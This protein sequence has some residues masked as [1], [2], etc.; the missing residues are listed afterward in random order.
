MKQ[1]E[2]KKTTAK[3]STGS[4]GTRAAKTSEKASVRT[5]AEVPANSKQLIHQVLPY[6]FAVVAFFLALCFFLVDI[7]NKPDSMG[8]IGKFVSDILLGFFGFGA[9]LIPLLLAYLAFVWRKSI[10]AGQTGYKIFFSC[11]CIILVSALIHVCV[12]QGNAELQTWNPVSLWKT[13]CDL[14]SGGIVGG[15]LGQ[16]SFLGLRFA[17]SLI[18]IIAVLL[19]TVMFLF[20]M[21][22]DN[23]I[24]YFKYKAR[25]RAERKAE[26]LARGEDPVFIDKPKFTPREV[27]PE[28]AAPASRKRKR[29]FDVDIEPD[30]VTDATPEDLG[31]EFMENPA[32]IAVAPDEKSFDDIINGT[33]L[34]PSKAVAAA[35]APLKKT[36]KVDEKELDDSLDALFGGEIDKNVSKKTEDDIAPWEDKPKKAESDDDFITVK[37][38]SVTD[39]KPEKPVFGEQLRAEIYPPISLLAEDKNAK[40][41]N[42]TAELRSTAEKLQETLLSFNVKTKIVGYSRGP[43]V[44]RYELQ[45]EAGTRVRSISNLVDDIALNLAASGGVRI[46]APIP[47]KSAVGIEV[48]NKSPSTVYLR[49]ILES[50]KFSESKSKVTACLGADVAGNP[51]IFDISKMPHLLIAGATGMGKSVCINCLIISLLYK[52]QPTDVKL[53]LI[54][55]KTVEF[56][57]YKDIP[58]LIAPI[59]TEPK[60]AAGALIKMVEE[61]ERRFALIEEVGVRDIKS[62]NEAIKNDPDREHLPQIVIIIDELADLMMTTPDDVENSICRLAQKARAAGMHIIIGTQRPSV[63]VITGLIKANVPSRIACTVASQVDSRTIIDIAGAEKLMGR[64]DMLYAPVG[65]SKPLR[66]QGAFVS[67]GEVEAVCDYIKTNTGKAEYDNNIV[68]G[69]E[70]AAA[71]LDAP[72]KGGGGSADMGADDGSDPMLRPAIELAIDCGKI[73]TSLIQRR[74]SLGYGRAAKLIDKMEQ[75]GYVSAQDGQKPREVLITKQ[76]YMEM[77]VNN[78]IQ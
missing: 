78:D 25:V 62:Y 54:D 68:E 53:L 56:K 21:T 44:T 3:K 70:E 11:A 10:D 9:F 63:D 35:G 42:Y 37:T 50:P 57:I 22:P 26:A 31:L 17:G 49:T 75:L 14:A 13:G 29:S 40:P 77:V 36:V 33:D 60:K 66:V 15:L 46:E 52:A 20:G 43:T 48:P 65:A 16:L 23:I 64:G 19:I 69:I 12:L 1:N 32:E 47:G 24:I 45:P 76:M 38:E 71:K 41:D 59:V 5:R 6:I 4:A 30:V 8:I 61:M 2:K 72:K 39:I 55:P 34:E 7:L 74:L 28:I 67:D 58:H 51:I 73:S 27:E 18:V